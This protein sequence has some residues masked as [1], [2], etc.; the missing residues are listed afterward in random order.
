MNLHGCPVGMGLE[1]L[2]EMRTDEWY[3]P[4]DGYMA[5]EIKRAA[6]S[7]TDEQIESRFPPD[8]MDALRKR[9]HD[10]FGQRRED[11]KQ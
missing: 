4:G 10:R 5:K 6:G 3:R 11:C 8:A 9:M 2:E 1:M 7:V